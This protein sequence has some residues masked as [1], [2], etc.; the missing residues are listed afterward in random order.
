MKFYI[1]PVYLS[2]NNKR[3]DHLVTPFIMWKLFLVGV[4][5]KSF[6]CDVHLLLQLRMLL[7]YLA[8][9][10][11]RVYNRQQIMNNI[12]P[13]ERA[14]NDRAIDNY[15]KKYPQENLCLQ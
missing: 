14:L 7:N 13:D 12:Y 11:G 9:H 6:L 15:I 10:S 5:G 4:E 8:V 1:I 2:H 3:D